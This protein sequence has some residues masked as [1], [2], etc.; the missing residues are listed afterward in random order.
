LLSV[1]SAG[2]PTRASG[3]VCLA[4]AQTVRKCGLEAGVSGW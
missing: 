3:G 1:T 4:Q 2:L